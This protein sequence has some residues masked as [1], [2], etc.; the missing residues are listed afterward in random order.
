MHM[1]V[2]SYFFPKVDFSLSSQKFLFTEEFTGKVYSN[3]KY[4]TGYLK[5]SSQSNNQTVDLQNAKNYDDS[6]KDDTYALVR[7]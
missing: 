2:C 4:V 3:V 5:D 7:G 1:N 6:L